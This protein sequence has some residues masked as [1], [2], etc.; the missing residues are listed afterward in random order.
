MIRD[1]DSSNSDV[2]SNQPPQTAATAATDFAFK[3]EAIYVP[4]S[5]R[6]AAMFEQAA[7]ILAIDGL[8]LQAL[9]LVDWVPGLS[10]KVFCNQIKS[11]RLTTEQV[12]KGLDRPDIQTYKQHRTDETTNAM[13]D[14]IDRHCFELKR[15]IKIGDQLVAG[16]SRTFLSGGEHITKGGRYPI[17]AINDEGYGDFSV[18]HKTNLPAPDDGTWTNALGIKFLYRDGKEIWSWYEAWKT[19]YEKVHGALTPEHASELAQMENTERAELGIFDTGITA[20]QGYILPSHWSNLPARE[21]L[22]R[23]GVTGRLFSLFSA[24]WENSPQSHDAPISFWARECSA[25]LE[26]SVAANTVH[27]IAVRFRYPA[28]FALHSSLWNIDLETG[29]LAELGEQALDPSALELIKA[30]AA[31]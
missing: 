11:G 15:V 12:V 4:L 10:S 6:T 25:D 17:I 27:S 19:D 26:V 8:T 16:E 2:G 13:S 29:R 22:R 20:E 24:E 31:R 28:G 23:S 5:V 14:A 18:C 21:V 9:F 1:R 3:A 30:L 7:H